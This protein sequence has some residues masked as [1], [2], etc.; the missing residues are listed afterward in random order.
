MQLSDGGF[1]VGIVQGQ[2]WSVRKGH[3]VE[4]TTDRKG[5][6]F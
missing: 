2:C 6:N 5:S 3:V 4:I 1:G